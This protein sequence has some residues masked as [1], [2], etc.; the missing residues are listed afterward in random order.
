M[1]KAWTPLVASSPA[2]PE[3]RIREEAP[4]AAQAWLNFTLFVPSDLPAGLR[5]VGSTLRPEAP[6]GRASGEARGRPPWT[7]SNRSAY[8]FELAG[9]G[10][11]ARLKQF[12]YD[13][14]P[15]AFDHPSLWKCDVRPFLAL[16]EVGWLGTDYRGRA[17]ASLHLRGTMVELAVLEGEL[18]EADRVR[19]LEGL[20]PVDPVAAQRIEVTPLGLLAY[21]GRHPDRSIA[22]PVS[23]WRHRREPGGVP[24]RV[25]VLVPGQGKADAPLGRLGYTLDTI[26]TLGKR[27]APRETELVARARAAPGRTLRYLTTRIGDEGAIG[28][29]PVLDAQPCKSDVV[30]VRKTDVH[31]AWADDRFGPWEATWRQGDHVVLLL[32]RP[33]PDTDRRWFD[34]VLAAFLRS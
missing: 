16:G 31:V 19:L 32:A 5:V 26:F 29:P 24:L 2:A 30:G 15:P 20:V 1:P 8:R 12:L 27:D 10:C 17:A 13:W 25:V 18:A 21:A 28:W 4:A 6:T 22:V 7:P 9:G 14:A 34:G 23:Y 3:G 33:A 11:R